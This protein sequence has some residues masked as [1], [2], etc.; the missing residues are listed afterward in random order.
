MFNTG[1]LSL[2]HQDGRAQLLPSPPQTQRFYQLCA[3]T[4]RARHV[5]ARLFWRHSHRSGVLTK[6]EPWEWERLQWT[7]PKKFMRES[8][9]HFC[10]L[11]GRS[12]CAWGGQHTERK[13]SEQDRFVPSIG[14]IVWTPVSGMAK[15]F[16]SCFLDVP[17]RSVRRT[18]I[19]C[20]RHCFIR[21]TSSVDL[22]H[23]QFFFLEVMKY[24]LVITWT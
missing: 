2:L 9:P 3:H 1:T 6:A 7:S 10:G 5:H 15:S 4:H 13:Y 12:L 16:D 20:N 19:F 22:F 18:H 23:V 24:K 14:W 17:F 11:W 8:R 21:T